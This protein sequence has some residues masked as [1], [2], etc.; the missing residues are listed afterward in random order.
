MERTQARVV[1]TSPLADSNVLPEPLTSLDEMTVFQTW[2]HIGSHGGAL[3]IL[4][5]EASPQRFRISCPGGV[6][7]VQ[8]IVKSSSGDG[9]LQLRLRPLRVR[10]LS[11]QGSRD[12]CEGWWCHRR[13][14]AAMSRTGEEGSAQRW[15][16]S[17]R[18][19]TQP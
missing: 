17:G 7:P 3:A 5:V 4:M 10:F 18:S 6:Q 16:G 14:A 12:G 2:L 13:L 8:G 1:F 11:N 15:G 9:K 19:R